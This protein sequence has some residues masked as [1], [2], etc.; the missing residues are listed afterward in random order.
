MRCSIPGASQ[1]PRGGAPLVDAG[2]LAIV[3][4][5]LTE[6][7]KAPA[8]ALAS[9]AIRSRRGR[10]SVGVQ[11]I[12]PGEVVARIWEIYRDQAAVLMGTAAILFAL[13]FIAFLLLGG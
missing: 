12:R 5:R 4:Q 1:T 6:T 9:E 3:V 8:M 2:T 13:Q 7:S 11:Q 10:S